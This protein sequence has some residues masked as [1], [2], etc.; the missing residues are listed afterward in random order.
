MR[1]GLRFGGKLN[2]VTVSRRADH[3]YASINVDVEICPLPCKNQA[4]VGID[5]GVKTLATL[6]NGEQI[7]GSKPLKTLLQKLKLN[8]LIILWDNNKNRQ[9]C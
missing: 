2:G 7:E 1:E 3:W 5:L 9:F 4:R 6:S 8:T